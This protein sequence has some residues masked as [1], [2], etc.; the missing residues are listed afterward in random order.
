MTSKSKI[1]NSMPQITN[2]KFFIW[3][4]IQDIDTNKCFLIFFRST[5][6]V[7]KLEMKEILPPNLPKAQQSEEDKE[8]ER[9]KISFMEK[10]KGKGTKK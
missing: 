8:I 10:I 6:K 9:N 1:R 2:S 5:K 3:T 4:R 7:A